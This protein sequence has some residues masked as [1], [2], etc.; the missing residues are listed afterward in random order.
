MARGITEQDVHQAAYKVV[1]AGERPTVERIRAHLGTGSPNTVIRYL[2]SWWLALASRLEEEESKLPLPDAPTALAR[3]AGEWWEAAIREATAHAAAG[4][5]DAH[6]ALAAERTALND[7]ERLRMG[8]FKRMEADIVAAQQARSISEQRLLDAQQLIDQ[9]R[10]QM[11]DLVAQRDQSIER[12]AQLDAELVAHVARLAT[13]E[14]EDARFRAQNVEHVRAVENR[15]HAEVDRARQEIR[16]LQKELEMTRQ[17]HQSALAAQRDREAALQERVTE[18]VR[19]AA[20]AHAQA[21]SLTQQTPRAGKQTTPSK[22]RKASAQSN[23]ASKKTVP[24][25]RR[26]DRPKA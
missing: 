20:V 3:L 2:D 4:L 7:H 12:A 26:A 24:R 5:A 19:D 11:I 17:A 23:A 21:A 14:D 13:R 1:I 10:T 16:A 6:A 25:R 8:E 9:Q 22:K 15:S 18:A